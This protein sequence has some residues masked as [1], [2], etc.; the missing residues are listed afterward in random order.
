MKYK[1]NKE[2]VKMEKIFHKKLDN[3]WDVVTTSKGKQEFELMIA[4][5]QAIIHTSVSI[6]YPKGDSVQ[7][8]L[9]TKSDIGNFTDQVINSMFEDLSRIV[10]HY[11][12]PSYKK[13]MCKVTFDTKVRDYGWFLSQVIKEGGAK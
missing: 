4:R 10:H 13:L 9:F 11:G 3:F 7:T 8:Y 2:E 6:N 1:T 12:G 5:D